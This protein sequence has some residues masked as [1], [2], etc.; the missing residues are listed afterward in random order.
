MMVVSKLNKGMLVC[1][2]LCL[3]LFFGCRSEQNKSD[4]AV[5]SI[6]V[7]S[8]KPKDLSGKFEV[9]EIV[10]L[11]TTEASILTD[12]TRV[13]IG[14]EYILT[15]TRG[16]GI[17]LW[18]RDGRFIRKIGRRG[19]GPNEY[20]D[21][22]DFQLDENQK[23]IYL[24]DRTRQ[25]MMVY[26]LEGNVISTMNK[27]MWIDSFCKTEDGYWVYI[28]L[29]WPTAGYALMLLDDNFDK[30]KGEFF[31][32]N[33]F[34]T[35]TMVPRFFGDGA[36][37]Y[38]FAYPYSNVIYHL[39]DGKPQPWLE[40]DFGDR[41]LPYDEIRTTTDKE[42]CERLDQ[43]RKYLGNIEDMVLCDGEI[44]FTFSER[45]PTREPYT[46]Y[47]AMY[48]T[49]DGYLE[50]YDG[51]SK[52]ASADPDS[53]YP[54]KSMYFNKPIAA[55]G[56]SWVYL[57]EPQYGIYYNLDMLKEKVSPEID[58]DSNPLLFFVKQSR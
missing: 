49:S 48:D 36:G 21:F 12:V 23:K 7:A 44:S 4:A 46:T 42:L 58:F 9:V 51:S 5:V 55:S 33:L 6:D 20:L 50:L 26:N 39:K 38:Y 54:V 27:P 40:V 31:P 19:N 18:G 34:F 43:E 22:E 32:Q 35:T 37:E 29:N 1:V 24:H 57:I 10:P 41:T 2:P 14:K 3:A 16:R 17:D 11:E 15:E 45:V 52:S 8:A 53:R 28:P 56:D 25:R 47:R 13:L 30:V